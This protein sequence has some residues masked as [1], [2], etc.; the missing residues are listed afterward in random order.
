[1]VRG[2]GAFSADLTLTQSMAPSV[3]EIRRPRM[4]A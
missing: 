4:A 3:V 2:S 1:V